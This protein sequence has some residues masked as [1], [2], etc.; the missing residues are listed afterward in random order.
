MPRLPFIR[1]YGSSGRLDPIEHVVDA[2][3]RTAI[4][5]D[6]SRTSDA[7]PDSGVRDPGAD[8]ASA[9]AACEL[10]ARRRE[11]VFIGYRILRALVVEEESW[12]VHDYDGWWEHDDVPPEHPTPI[13]RVCEWAIATRDAGFE[14]DPPPDP[15]EWPP[16]LPPANPSGPPPSSSSP[17]LPAPSPV[18]PPFDPVARYGGLLVHDEEE[19]ITYDQ[20][21][22][23]IVR[24]DRIKRIERGVRFA[25][26]IVRDYFGACFLEM[27]LA[28]RGEGSNPVAMDAD[29]A[30]DEPKDLIE[31]L[32]RWKRQR[33]AREPLLLLFE[34]R[35]RFRPEAGA[36]NEALARRLLAEELE[37]IG[38]P[39]PWNFPHDR[40]EELIAA[41]AVDP[42]SGLSSELRREAFDTIWTRDLAESDGIDEWNAKRASWQN[43]LYHN[44]EESVRILAS[45]NDPRVWPPLLERFGGRKRLSLG[46]SKGLRDL[47]PLAALNGLE[48]LF[49]NECVELTDFSPLARLPSLRRLYAH[50]TGARDLSS[51]A[52]LSRLAH[53]GFSGCPTT[54]LSPL[55]ALSSLTHLNLTC[56][57]ATDLAP[58]AGLTSLVE[59]VLGDRMYQKEPGITD[60]SPLRGLIR[61]ERLRICQARGIRDLAPLAGL[62]ALR[63]LEILYCGAEDLAPL[64]GLRSLEKVVLVEC[65]GMHDLA[66]LAGLPALH[67]VE[68]RHCAR[69]RDLAPLAAAPSLRSIQAFAP[70]GYPRLTLPPELA[71]RKDLK[72][73]V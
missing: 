57:P 49:V 54:D 29:A 55:A 45:A 27:A 28:A 44:P 14:S 20:C 66:P 10:A 33:V 25:F 32:R 17:P 40:A 39:L 16:P 7:E 73:S 60:L 15:H 21:E 13:E 35:T 4:A 72:I 61:L 24:P 3:L 30:A 18:P 34:M 36:A 70:P 52:G 2:C 53:L 9:E 71:G 31:A 19:V 47:T 26:P 64:A 48:E 46:G 63:E 1:P 11:L 56:S 42:R 62:V 68:L 51:L 59:L 67:T 8:P 58:L 6:A 43:E 69:I 5:R 50:G 23:A 22:G 38:E 37:P 65:P 12:K 41:L